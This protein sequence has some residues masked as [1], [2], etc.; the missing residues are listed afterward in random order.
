[1]T[2]SHEL[3]TPLTAISGWAQ[4]LATS[5]LKE[6]QKHR[7]LNT[8]RRNV[9]VQTQLIEDLLDVSSMLSGTFR[10]KL[11]MV[12]LT[13]IMDAALE[14]GRSALQAKAITVERV[15]DD[16]IEPIQGDPE[17]LR[18]ITWNLLSNAIKF[19]PPGGRVQ[20][21]LERSGDSVQMVVSDSGIGIA[22]D[23]LPFAFDRFRQQEGGEKRRYAGIGLGLALVRH[24]VELHGGSVTAD[25]AGE[26]QGT[27]VRVLLP[28]RAA[29][30]LPPD[31]PARP[32]S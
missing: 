31:V 4:M 12:D 19:T 15:V 24:L 17:R 28:A 23:F 1:M 10:L 26:N 11:Q 32:V 6:D 13:Q 7:A 29:E 21:R 27:T 3:R 18:Q 20:L 9:R 30:A 2:L 8:I 14:A 16:A 22:P 25:S 5:D